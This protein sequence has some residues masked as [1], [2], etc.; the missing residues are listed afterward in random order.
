MNSY[1]TLSLVEKLDPELE[2]D[3]SHLL[4]RV[5]ED[6]ASIG[7][8]PPMN[9]DEALQYWQGVLQPGTML[10]VAREKNT[11]V[12]TIQ[13]LLVAK[14]NAR[15]RAEIAKLMVHPEHRRKGIAGRLMHTAE[16][17]ATTEARE[18][19]V[20]DTREG[21]PS[22]ILYTS[23]GY[24]QGGRIPDFVKSENGEFQATIIYYKKL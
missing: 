23:L 10:W 14:P 6:G 1:I 3:L 12:G 16:A 21:D 19:I 2:L 4:I 13:L 15:H 20:L 11:I 18:L 5:V 9:L 22:N 24:I 17:A 7:F 8:L